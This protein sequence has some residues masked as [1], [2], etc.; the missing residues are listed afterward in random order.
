MVSVASASC[1]LHDDKAKATDLSNG[2]WLISDPR[3]D[4]CRF[5]ARQ[6][7]GW[8]VQAFAKKKKSERSISVLRRSSHVRKSV[9]YL[10]ESDDDDPAAI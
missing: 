3:F 9:G 1:T 2:Y 5:A 6:R 7:R 8:K 10:I 4:T